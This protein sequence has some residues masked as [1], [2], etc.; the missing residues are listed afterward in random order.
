MVATCK[1]IVDLEQEAACLSF[2]L[3]EWEKKF[4]H[5]APEESRGGCVYVSSATVPFGWE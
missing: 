1:H 5:T 3:I 2:S 4:K